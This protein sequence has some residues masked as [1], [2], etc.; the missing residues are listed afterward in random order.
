VC[1]GRND[2][3][4]TGNATLGTKALP[5]RVLVAQGGAPFSGVLELANAGSGICARMSNLDVRCWGH[6]G[7]INSPYPAPYHLILSQYLTGVVLPL[8]G[9]AS[10]L[11]PSVSYLAYV[12]PSAQLNTDVN[13][14][15]HGQ[16]CP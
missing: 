6:V 14:Y 8:A 12:T 1:W 11:D 9:S 3:Y 7:E 15:G 13:A 5:T 10:T 2:N 16:P 4:Q